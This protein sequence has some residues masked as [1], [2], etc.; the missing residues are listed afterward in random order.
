MPG[1]NPAGQNPGGQKGGNQRTT[2]PP[3]EIDSVA[4][5]ALKSLGDGPMLKFGHVGELSRYYNCI[6]IISAQ[7]LSRR[8]ISIII[9]SI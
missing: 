1:M 4:L 3:G 8:E 2:L 7:A 5:A 9:N 6:Q